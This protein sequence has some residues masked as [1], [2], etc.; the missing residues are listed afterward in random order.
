ETAAGPLYL[1]GKIDKLDRD[2]DTLLVRDIKTGGGKPRAPDDPPDLGID[3]QL[4]LYAR[5]AQLMATAWDT[6]SRVGVAYIYLRSGEPDRSWIGDDYARLEQAAGDW[7]AAA[8]E[9]LEHSAYIR[10]PK[11]DDCRYCPYKPV[12][13]P[14]MDRAPR[15]LEDARVPRRIA[16]LKAVDPDD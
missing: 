14:E 6:P 1:L 16:R 11:P 10:S 9:A 15:V 7:F 5:V 12:C 2:G 8:R 13:A 4:A 3:L